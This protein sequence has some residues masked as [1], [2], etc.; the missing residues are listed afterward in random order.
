MNTHFTVD[1][2]PFDS[3]CIFNAFGRHGSIIVCCNCIDFYHKNSALLLFQ[4]FSPTPDTRNAI[5]TQ[6]LVLAA[7]CQLPSQPVSSV[8]ISLTRIIKQTAIPTE[9]PSFILVY[10][11]SGYI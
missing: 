4:P 11:T 10:T 5:R 1:T 6:P 3:D 9:T 2:I 8:T 7:C